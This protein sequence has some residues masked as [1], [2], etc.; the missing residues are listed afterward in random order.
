MS[1]ASDHARLKR[2]ADKKILAFRDFA[3]IDDDGCL[4]V[5]G[6]RSQVF[7]QPKESVALARW[8]LDVFGKKS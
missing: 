4:S 6:S 8:I 5:Y 7:L 1:K 3:Y 2:S